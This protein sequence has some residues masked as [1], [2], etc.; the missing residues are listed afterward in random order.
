LG[1]HCRWR[2]KEYG[3]LGFLKGQKGQCDWS[4]GNKGKW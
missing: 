2:L 3:E 4:L 1:D